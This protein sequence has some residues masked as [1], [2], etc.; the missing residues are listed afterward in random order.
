MQKNISSQR[1]L[2]FYFEKCDT[3]LYGEVQIEKK[4][5]FAEVWENRIPKL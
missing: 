5:K 3:V 4:K 2:D 1:I